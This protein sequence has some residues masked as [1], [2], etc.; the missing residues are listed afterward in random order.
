M[1]A[2]H[3]HPWSI[4]F[5]DWLQSND[6]DSQTTRWTRA[7]GTSELLEIGHLRHKR[8]P[9]VVFLHG[10]G[11]DAV[12]PNI[13]LFR[14]LLIA[15]FNI[16]TADLD[17]HGKSNTTWFAEETLPSLVSEMMGN[18]EAIQ[19]SDEKVHVCGYSLGALLVLDYA[20]KNP[21]LVKTVSL[22]GMP[23][24]LKSDPR[25]AFELLTPFVNS[26]RGALSD[27]GLSGIHPAIGPVLRSRYPLRLKPKE[28]R[29]YLEVAG[30]IIRR[31]EPARLISSSTLPMLYVA[32]SLDFIGYHPR[33]AK[34]M[35]DLI[36]STKLRR[37]ILPGE[38]HFSSMLS[39]KM[40]AII[41]D[42][43]RNTP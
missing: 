15:G 29:P 22:I 35:D 43:L 4:K 30:Q 41:A 25:I 39:P 1:S 9:I 26:Y 34:F 12:F 27:Y 20:V 32:G 36:Q 8:R 23:I 6:F 18:C 19:T 13:D 24:T 28:S 2:L 3:R 37:E 5:L 14:Q 33:S 11:N 10:L 7:G 42:F 31:M 16:V 38:T 40:P 17:G 21:D